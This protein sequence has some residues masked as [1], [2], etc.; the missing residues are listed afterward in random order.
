MCAHT[1]TLLI[2][3]CQ[4]T[5]FRRGV[6]VDSRLAVHSLFDARVTVT[7]RRGRRDKRGGRQMLTFMVGRDQTSTKDLEDSDSDV[8]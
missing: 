3:I 7:G 6:G 4:F 8:L 5:N 2:R 1:S